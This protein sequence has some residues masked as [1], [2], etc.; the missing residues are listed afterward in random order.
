MPKTERRTILLT[1]ASG[2]VG[3]AVLRRLRDFDV[4]CLVHRSPVC[5]PDVTAVRGDI[6]EPMLGLGESRLT[7]D[8]GLFGDGSDASDWHQT[9]ARLLARYGPFVLAYLETVVRIADWRAS[10][11]TEEAR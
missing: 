8:L 3:R 5:G 1:G 10:A 11:G 6:A 9:A 7:V 2:V 4:V